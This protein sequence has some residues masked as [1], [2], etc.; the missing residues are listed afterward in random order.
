MAAHPHVLRFL[1]QAD[2]YEVILVVPMHPQ[3]P[4][5]QHFQAMVKLQFPLYNV[6]FHLEDSQTIRARHPMVCAWITSLLASAW[7][8]RNEEVKTH[9][10]SVLVDTFKRDN[11]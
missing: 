5:W 2:R 7:T 9:L 8:F 10:R 1:D 6:V 3:R 4:S 11:H